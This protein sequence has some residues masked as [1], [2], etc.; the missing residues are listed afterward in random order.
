[1]ERQTKNIITRAWVENELWFYNTADI[2][3]ITVTFLSLTVALGLPIYLLMLLAWIVLD[4]FWMKITLLCVF[5]GPAAFLLLFLIYE[6]I[7]KLVDRHAL[8]KGR[9]DIV[10][11]TVRYKR[12][13]H[14]LRRGS[15]RM[16][17]MLAFEEF[18]EIEVESTEYHLTEAGDQF[19]MAVYYAPRARVRLWYPCRTHRYVED[20]Q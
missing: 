6:L 17:Y 19:Y 15:Y 5:G 1:M 7:R 9:F 2:K 4:A 3:S 8:K 18:G 20:F 16:A 14:I 12:E 10:V 13:K 11:R